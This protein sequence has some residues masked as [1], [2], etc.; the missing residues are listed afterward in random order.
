PYRGTFWPP[1]VPLTGLDWGLFNWRQLEFHGKL[2]LL[3]GGLVFAD[4]ITTVSPTYAREIRTPELGCGLEG[5]LDERSDALY[6]I[7][8]GIDVDEW[9]P[10]T[11]PLIP[12]RYSAKSPAGKSKCKAALQRKLGLP[13]KAGVPLFGFVGRLVEQKG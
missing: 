1:D 2:N 3:K 13:V 8:N 11:D 12:A 10:A 7:L 4:A 9:N 5:V 6:G